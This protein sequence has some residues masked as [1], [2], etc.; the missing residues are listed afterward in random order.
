MTAQTC[1][2][3]WFSRIVQ[4]TKTPE[5]AESG[6]LPREKPRTTPPRGAFSPPPRPNFRSC[7][8]SPSPAPPPGG[9][10]KGALPQLRLWAERAASPPP[11]CSERGTN[12]VSANG[13]TANLVF[14]DK[15]TFCVLP[16]TYFYHPKSDRAYLFPSKSITFAA[17]PLMLTPFVRNRS[18]RWLATAAPSRTAKIHLVTRMLK[19]A[20]PPEL[21]IKSVLFDSYILIV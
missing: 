12:G 21:F 11:S 1:F 2:F 7:P 16:L 14:F 18:V 6:S 19:E 17:S 5:Q 20:G 10:P 8:R 3:C 15:G 9:P 4:R 13:V